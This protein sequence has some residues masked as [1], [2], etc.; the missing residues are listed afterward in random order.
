MVACMYLQGEYGLGKAL[1]IAELIHHCV[2]IGNNEGVTWKTHTVDFA[3][4]FQSV[5]RISLVW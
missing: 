3:W 4:S 5:F 2:T 1:F